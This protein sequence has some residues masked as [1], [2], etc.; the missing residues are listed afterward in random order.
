MITTFTIENFKAIREPVWPKAKMH[1]RFILT[2]IGG[3]QFG[4]GLDARKEGQPDRDQVH[5]LPEN[6]WA[7]IWAQYSVGEVVCKVEKRA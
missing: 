1:N 3:V 5:R 4:H 2:D 6:V 7:E